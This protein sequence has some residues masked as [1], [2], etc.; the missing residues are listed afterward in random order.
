M[1]LAYQAVEIAGKHRRE[2]QD[3]EGGQEEGT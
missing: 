2:L 1:S 3:G